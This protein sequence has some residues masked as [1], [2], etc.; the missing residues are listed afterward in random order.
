MQGSGQLQLMRRNISIWRWRPV[1]NET[2]SSAGI[3]PIPGRNKNAKGKS[4]I[5]GMASRPGQSTVDQLV[6]FPTAVLQI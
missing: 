5:K 2:D 6:K 3:G 4:G 1:S